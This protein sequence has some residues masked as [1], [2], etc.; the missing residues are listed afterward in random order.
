[1]SLTTIKALVPG[2]CTEVGGQFRSLAVGEEA[3]I[4][5]RFAETL[6]PTKA[7]VIGA[8]KSAPKTAEAV[9]PSEASSLVGNV[10]SED[11]G[12]VTNAKQAKKAK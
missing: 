7:E 10:A 4:S 2:I 1:M 5:T 3:S 11:G 6:P 9:M 12:P 8:V